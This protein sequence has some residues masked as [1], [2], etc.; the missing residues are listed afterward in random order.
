MLMILLHN[1]FS[2]SFDFSFYTIILLL[3]SLIFH[4]MHHDIFYNIGAA[5]FVRSCNP[6]RYSSESDIASM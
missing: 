6:S 3:Y 4:D 5:H 1:F 2:R